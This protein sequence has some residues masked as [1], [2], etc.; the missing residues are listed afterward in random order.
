MKRLTRKEAIRKFCVECMGGNVNRKY[1]KACTAP[2]C[3]LFPYRLGRI[4]V[5]PSETPVRTRKTR[6]TS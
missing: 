1:V 2:D 4:V 6:K 3:P 5:D